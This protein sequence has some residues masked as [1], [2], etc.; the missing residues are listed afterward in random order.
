MRAAIRD[1]CEP[2]S[3]LYHLLSMIDDCFNSYQVNN[4]RLQNI[5]RKFSLD[6]SGILAWVLSEF[7]ES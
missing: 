7:E 4:S 6:V 2:R 5:D 3:Y 1:T